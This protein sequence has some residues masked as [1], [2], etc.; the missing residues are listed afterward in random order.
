MRVMMRSR[1]VEGN[2]F[3]QVSSTRLAA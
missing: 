2:R 3:A 1:G